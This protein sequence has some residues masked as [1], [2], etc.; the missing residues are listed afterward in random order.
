[1]NSKNTVKETDEL[2]EGT[3]LPPLGVS[4]ALAG[5]E[6]KT[7]RVKAERLEREAANRTGMGGVATPYLTQRAADVAKELG[8]VKTEITELEGMDDLAVRTWAYRRT[9]RP[10]QLFDEMVP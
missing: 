2:P 4:R 5:T 7:L 3:P 9:G 1:M 6:I 10:Q 8:K